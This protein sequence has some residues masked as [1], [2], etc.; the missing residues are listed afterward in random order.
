[1]HA[2]P[3]FMFIYYGEE[4]GVQT[5]SAGKAQPPPPCAVFCG[6]LHGDLAL[7]P[8]SAVWAKFSHVLVSDWL[9]AVQSVSWH[10]E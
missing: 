7:E 10:R 1:M 2:L 9:T 8:N 5:K 3:Y 4:R 6:L